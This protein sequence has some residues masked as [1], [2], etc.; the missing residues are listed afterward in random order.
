MRSTA[1]AFHGKTRRLESADE[2]R[3]SIRFPIELDVRYR[4]GDATF[5]SE[6]TT[7]KTLNVSSH[8]VLFT[9]DRELD[10]LKPLELRI[11]WPVLLHCTTAI[12]LVARG[13]IVRCAEGVAVLKIHNYEF[14][15]CCKGNGAV[16]TLPVGDRLL[17]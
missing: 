15:T 12:D 6:F 2:R 7:G 8:G 16:V 3:Q 10:R 17:N 4:T 13:W 14:R 9:T 1:A 11:R 5:Q